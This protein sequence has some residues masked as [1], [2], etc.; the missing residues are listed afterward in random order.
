M[1]APSKEE[2]ARAMTNAHLVNA[3]RLHIIA[4]DDWVPV[5]KAEYQRRYEAQ[6]K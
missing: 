4:G 6:Q 1:A 3:L 2:Q 5:L